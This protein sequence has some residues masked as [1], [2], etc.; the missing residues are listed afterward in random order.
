MI[1]LLLS[2]ILFYFYSCKFDVC[3]FSFCFTIRSSKSLDRT[4]HAGSGRNTASTANPNA[5]HETAPAKK[6]ASN[7]SSASPPFYPSGSSNKETTVTTKKEVHSGS[8]NRSFRPPVVEH[9]YNMSPSNSLLRGKSVNDSIGMDKLHIDDSAPPGN[10]KPLNN[11]HLPSS[12]SSSSASQMPQPRAQG[13]AV[14]SM[15]Q[16]PQTN[17]QV[18]RV[19]PSAAQAIQQNAGHNRGQPPLEASGQPLGQ[20][21]LGSS[22]GSSPPKAGL[23]LIFLNLETCFFHSSYI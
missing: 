13:R 20:R 17:N 2:A 8:N 16:P 1:L 11:V 18:S 4:A 5:E 9:N 12:A 6:V 22:Q 14:A 23:S 10:A 7:L 21:S 19:L 3:F 15:F